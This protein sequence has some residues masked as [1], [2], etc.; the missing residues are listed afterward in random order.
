MKKYFKLFVSCLFVLM[1]FSCSNKPAFNITGSW[2]AEVK[3]KSEMTSKEDPF[4]VIANIYTSQ[5]N[6]FSFKEDGTYE[7]NI[8]QNTDK[9]ESLVEELDEKELFDLYSKSNSSVLLKGSYS[10]NGKKLVLKTATISFG[11]GEMSY[12]EYYRDITVLGP[13]EA[14][15]PV[16]LDSENKLIIQG[17]KFSKTE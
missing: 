6:E 3:L 15:I 12:S 17:I 10:L 1:A 4:V 9:V 13:V 7:R 11:D 16:E 2:G 5:K 14:K 8:I